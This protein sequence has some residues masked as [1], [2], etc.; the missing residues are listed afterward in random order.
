MFVT[1]HA[2]ER[3]A[4]RIPN[5]LGYPTDEQLAIAAMYHGEPIHDKAHYKRQTAKYFKGFVFIY[6]AKNKNGRKLMT[7]VDGSKYKKI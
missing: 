1:H 5:R 3:I 6:S 2:R 4:Q 7:V